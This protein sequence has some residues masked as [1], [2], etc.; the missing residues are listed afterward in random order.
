MDN[1]PK[2]SRWFPSVTR[3]WIVIVL[4]GFIIGLLAAALV[5]LGNPPNM[6]I[7]IACFWRDIAGALGLHRMEAVQ[8]LRPEIFAIVL[9]VAIPAWW[10]KELS[11]R[12]GSA[13]GTRFL[14]GMFMMV[15]ALMFLGC[16]TRMVLRLAGGDL[17]ALTGIAGFAA[18]VGLGTVFLKRGFSLGRSVRETSGFSAWIFPATALL[19]LCAACIAPAIFFASAKG[20]GSMHAPAWLSITAGLAV[21]IMAFYSRFCFA[22]G[23][24]DLFLFRDYH[25][26][27]GVVT[28]FAGAAVA[29]LLFGQLVWDK[30]GFSGQP[31]AHSDWL[32]NGL[33]MLLVGLG[34]VL[35]GGCPLRQLVL[36]AQGNLDSF[37][38]ILGM[39]FGAAIA[40]NFAIASTPA[41]PQLNGKIAVGV[42][43]SFC[44]L[45]SLIFKDRENA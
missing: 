23:I 35:L 27:A 42:G 21:G 4:S 10:R 22:G 43:I 28:L 17:N 8:Y 29:N 45:V 24:R 37:V 32:W 19:L 3:D 44:I 34:A 40:H 26:L 5:K 7:C 38:T 2:T 30:I 13:P 6:G 20:P 9:G 11:A 12:S 33:G 36:A 14:L 31:I 15:G 25:L 39:C 16:P 41:G 18:G 1:F